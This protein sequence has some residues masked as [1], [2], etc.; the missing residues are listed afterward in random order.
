MQIL[1]KYFYL[2]F[3]I[4][5]FVAFLISVPFYSGDVKNHLVW[6][7]SLLQDGAFGFYGRY[8][9]D[10]AFQNYPPLAMFLFA[11]SYKF[12]LLVNQ[13]VYSI[14]N[15]LPIFPSNLVYFF[16]WENVEIAFLKLPAIIS[17]FGITALIFVITKSLWS[18]I[19]LF[20]PATIYLSF[21]WGQIDYL[22]IMFLLG[23]LYLFFAKK[24]YWSSFL[25][26]LAL[27]S[28]QTVIIFWP[29]YLFL[30][31]REHGFK[32]LAKNLSVSIIIFY[33][34]YLPF[35]QFSFI[36]PVNLYMTNF[37]FV[38]AV[39]SVNSINFWGFLFDFKQISDSL[40]FLIFSYQNWGYIIFAI[41][42]FY[43][44]L[45]FLKK[46]KNMKHILTYFLIITLVYFFSLTRIHE[47]YLAP[48]IAFFS[49]LVFLDKKIWISAIIMSFIYFVNLYRGLLQPDMGIFNIWSSSVPFLKLLVGVYFLVIIYNIYIFVKND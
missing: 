48:A 25:F 4:F 37:T 30:I 49:I 13:T 35:H 34:A 27:L 38:A 42:M 18:F 16:Q 1:N 44:T 11:I 36:W 2:F 47:R 29:I 41:F 19:F 15:I 3:I 40:T 12:Y 7:K 14:N 23:S 20:N 10:F 6:A 17:N 43:P 26:V 9:H 24:I 39:T 33:L 46:P 5:F 8:F 45:I 22:P 31:L 28:K 21:V 32:V